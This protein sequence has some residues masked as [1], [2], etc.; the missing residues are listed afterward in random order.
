M[1]RMA[2]STR[3]MRRSVRVGSSARMAPVM[4][5][6]EIWVGGERAAGK[7]TSAWSGATG[8]ASDLYA[9]DDDNDAEADKGGGAEEQSQQ[10]EGNC[11]AG[12]VAQRQRGHGGAQRRGAHGCV[13]AICRGTDHARWILGQTSISRWTSLLA[14]LIISPWE[15]K[16]KP[17]MRSVG[18]TG[19]RGR[20]CAAPRSGGRVRWRSG[21]WTCDAGMRAW[22]L[23]PAAKARAK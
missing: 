21:A 20:T 10:G 8:S 3:R 7:R 23:A 1:P 2:L 13:L 5:L 17:R 15:E 22:R 4:R 14:R 12:P 19:G 9:D 18:N 11:V 6:V 16:G